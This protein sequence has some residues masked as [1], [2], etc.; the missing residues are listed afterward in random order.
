MYPI[1]NK[2]IAAETITARQL[3]AMPDDGNRYEIIAGKLH[4]MSPAGNRHGR[5]VMRL[6]SMLDQHVRAN[7][8]GTVYAA[9]T[10]F[11]ISRHPDTVRAPDVAFVGK[12]R[13]DAMGDLEGYLPLA[14]DLI[15]EVISPSDS[16]Q[17]VEEKAR[18]W[19]NA[20]TA[21]VLTVD[22]ASRTVRVR[23]AKKTIEVLSETDRLETADVVPGW[24]PN[25]A[26]FFV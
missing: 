23:R 3:L 21:I 22:P 1:A 12:E 10:G 19:L 11:L 25:I 17:Q 20:G 26:D 15:V 6:G 18:M 7:D 8:L 14:P 13:V 4:M 5:I 16:S 9:E 2:S 24:T